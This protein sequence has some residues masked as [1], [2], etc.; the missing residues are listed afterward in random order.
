[1]S[2]IT[3]TWIINNIDARP[4]VNG[5]VNVISNVHWRLIGTD[6]VNTTTRFG[7]VELDWP[8]S[9]KFIQFDELTEDQIIGFAIDILGNTAINQ[10]KTSILNELF[11]ISNPQKVKLIVPHQ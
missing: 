7:D 2:N 6:G 8:D 1:M 11:L 9:D 3:Y 10:Y 5:L 4:I